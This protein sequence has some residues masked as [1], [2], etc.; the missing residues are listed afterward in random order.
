MKIALTT[1]TYWP[2]I[3]GV[4]VVVDGLR[5]Y[6]AAWGHDVRVFAPAYPASPGDLAVQ[7]PPEVLR[8]S[9]FSMPLSREDRLGWPANR[10]RITRI[11]SEWKPDIVHSHTEFTIG[12][13][14]KVYCGRAGVPH[15]MTRHT[16]Y[17]DFIVSYVPVTPR[18][19]ARGIVTVWSRADYR[20]VDR[21][22]VPAEHLRQLIRSYGV[23]TPVEVI[24]NGV[25]L[26]DAKSATRPVMSERASRI[27]RSVEG[28]RI[29]V[30]VGRVAREK[31]I[32]FLLRAFEL[33]PQTPAPVVLLVVGDGPYRRELQSKV[34]EAGWG[35]KI[36]FT[37]YL[38]RSEVAALLSRS[39]VFL[40]ASK[41]ETQGLV[42]IEAMSCGTP[43]VAVKASG[44]DEVIDG[45]WGTELSP[46][47]PRVFADRVMELL[48]DEQLRR[49]RAAQGQEASRSWSL[50]RMAER[51][52]TLYESLL[53]A[54]RR[55]RRSVPAVLSRT[56][57][58]G[59]G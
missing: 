30:T 8:F 22:V 14:G 38:D 53:R 24:P 50:T 51:T 47:D 2:R 17:E 56:L 21:V 12:F 35:H 31:N 33:I 4:T 39:D 20:L 5:R 43:I 1:D 45:S 37:G 13:S 40:F 3:N 57:R 6:L 52:L 9:S 15:L 11:L 18:W 28:S 27:L 44:V 23:K 41:T 46:E 32:D 48:T 19:L 16:M 7:D 42:I 29:L 36:R 58:A 49:K 59:R 34:E 25:D 55:I 54:P 10:W 26:G